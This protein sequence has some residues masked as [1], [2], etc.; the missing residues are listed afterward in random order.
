MKEPKKSPVGYAAL[1]FAA[2]VLLG[3][4]ALICLSTVEASAKETGPDFRSICE[5][6]GEWWNGGHLFIVKKGVVQTGWV[7][8]RGNTY[9][10]HE[11]GTEKYPI[12]SATRGE[13]KIQSGKFYAFRETGRMITVDDYI[14][15]GPR[16][17]RL[18]LE[19]N[20]DKSVRYVYNTSAC[21]G[22]RRY[23]TKEHR[24]QEEQS[25][26]RWKSVGM[27]FWPDYIDW[28]R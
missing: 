12:G 28:Q 7:R 6:D 9:Y 17:K 13:M 22:Y 19:L 20:P 11:T 8:Y 4:I 27:Q 23:C 5:P 25:N 15:K 24:Y 26:G 18:S 10:C 16:R 1:A 2:I 3:L 14:K 21:F